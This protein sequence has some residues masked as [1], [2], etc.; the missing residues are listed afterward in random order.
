M[1]TR[2]QRRRG[3]ST[4]HATFTGALGEIT[5][6]TS[7][8]TVVVHD[9]STQ[10]GFPLLKE[11][12]AVDTLN[13][14]S[15]V[16]AASPSAGEVLQYN[17][18]DWVA[19]TPVISLAGFI[20]GQPEEDAQLLRLKADRAFTIPTNAAG[21]QSDAAVAADANT[22]IT[23]EKNGSSFGTLTFSAASTVGVWAV[24]ATSFAIGDVLGIVGPSAADAALEG[25]TFTIQGELG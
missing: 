19:V 25:I 23:L 14:L 11:E 20:P 16:D 6:D 13:D 18:N 12:D 4:E 3:T 17:G 8:N 5:V 10:G 21:S 7:K 1:A 9:G 15:D 24:S 22:V 2:V